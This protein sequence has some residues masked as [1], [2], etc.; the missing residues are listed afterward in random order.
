M[1]TWQVF[2]N[3]AQRRNYKPIL[4]KSNTIEVPAGVQY[5]SQCYQKINMKHLLERVKKRS[6]KNME[7]LP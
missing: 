3:T 1:A 4:R 2:I 5:H 6:E 7:S